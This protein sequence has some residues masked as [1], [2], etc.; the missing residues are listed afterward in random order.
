[1]PTRVERK[2]AGSGVFN[3]L[4]LGDI[5][6]DKLR[7][8]PCRFPI[9]QIRRHVMKVDRRIFPY[10]AQCNR[11]QKHSREAVMNLALLP[12]TSSLSGS[13]S[14]SVANV[15]ASPLAAR[16]PSNIDIFVW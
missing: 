13:Q 16:G 5:L 6:R 4:L 1:M 12:G 2:R 11:N 9:G 7:K 8:L 14:G 3:D 10:A 15:L